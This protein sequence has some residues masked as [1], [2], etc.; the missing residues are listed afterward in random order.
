MLIRYAFRAACMVLL[1]A[2]GVATSYAQ[3]KAPTAEQMLSVNGAQGREF[4]IAI[5]PNEINPFPVTSL[6]IYIASAYDTEAFVLDAAGGNERRY[7]ITANQ[8]RTLSD[9]TGET[10]WTWEIRQYEQVIQKGIR[11]KADKPISVYVLNGKVT[12][13]DGYL[14]IPTA[15][16]G[17][18][19]IVTTYYDFR[20]FK[21]WACGFVI[22]SRQSGTIVD[23]RLKG[24]GAGTA[25]TSGGKRIG[26]QFQVSLEEGDVYAVV[27]DGTSRGEFDLT[28]TEIRSNVPVGLISF[29]QRTTMPNLLINGNGRDHLCEMTPPV[30]TW[31][32]KYVTVE[33][34]R[35]GTNPNAR[36]DV[37]RVIASEPETRWTLKYY[38]KQSKTV[39]G[40]G[41]GYLAN[42]GDFA[43]LTQSQGPTF[44]THG[45]SVWE[46]DKPIFVMQYA[47][48]A[49]FDGDQLHDPFM[50]NV[51]P[52]EQFIPNTIFQTPTDTK[53]TTHKL[54]L[55]V[56][57]D[58]ND[59]D[60]VEN[61][62]SLVI[63]DVPVWNHPRSVAPT[64]LFNH[65]GNNLH[66]V[67][68][69]F[70]TEAKAHV[71]KGN[72]KVKFGGYIYG[73]GAVDSYGWPA[74]SGFRPTSVLDTMPPVLSADTLCGDYAYTA[75]EFRNIP[76]PPLAEPRDSDQVE[77]GVAIIDFM[78]EDGGPVLKSYNYRI[79]I[80]ANYEQPLPRDPSYREVKFLLEVIDK[81]KD[82]RA[83]FYVQDWADNFTYDT[84]E[85]FAPKLS[86]TPDPL[87][88]GEVRL[89]TSKQLDLSITNIGDGP[90][91]LTDATIEA[92]DYFKVV[93]GD[94]PP[95]VTLDPGQSHVFTIEYTGTRET[96]D[97]RSDF[98]LDTLVVTADCGETRIGLE[99]VA[100]I[101]CI[102]VEDFRAGT[103]GVGDT[104]CKAGGLRVRNP[105]SDTLV[106]TAI[107][108]YNGTNFTVTNLTPALPIRI[109]PKGEVFVE[110]ICYSRN[111][112]GTDSIDVTF[113]S[114]AD[115]PFC[116]SDSVS[117]WTGDTE[118]PGP[119]IIGHNWLKRR[120]NTLHPEFGVVNVYNSGNQVLTLAN[121][122]FADGT[123]Y[124]PPGSNEANY[125]FKLGSM[126]DNGTAVPSKQLS[127]GQSVFVEAWFRPAAVQ[128]YSATIQPEWAEDGVPGRTALL[129]GEGIIPDIETTGAVITCANSPEGVKVTR[130]LVI[131]N[132][133]SEDLTIS[134]IRLAAGTDPAWQFGAPPP[135]PTF[136]VPFA[137]GS[138]TYRVPIEFTRPAG[139]NNAFV[140]NVEFEHD[141]VPGNGQDA[142]ITPVTAGQ[143]FSVGSCSGP[144]IEVT[145]IDFGRNLANCETPIMEF[146]ITNTGGGNTPLEI[147]EITPVGADAAA[148]TIIGMNDDGGSPLALPFT[149]G[150]TRQ[151]VIRV[152]FEPTEPNAAPWNDRTY[153]AQFHIRNYVQGDQNELTPDTYV[154]VRGVGFVIPVTMTL[155]NDVEGQIVNP[156]DDDQVTF[157]VDAT[158]TNWNR[159]DVTQFVATV[160][161]PTTSLAL[162]RGSVQRVGLPADWVIAAPVVAPIA[163]TNNSSITFAANGTTPIPGDGDLFTFTMTLLLGPDFSNDQ[164]L[165]LEFDRACLVPYTDG[166]STEITN[167]ALTKRV[168]DIGGTQ[169]A[170]NPVMPNPV[171]SGRARADFA[172]GI[173]APTVIEV[174]D[175]RG[176]VVQRLVD[177]VLTAGEYTIEFPTTNLGNGVYFLRLQSADFTQTQQVVIG[178]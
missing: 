155:S 150:Q 68:I 77:T 25:R 171:T 178:N 139:N 130:D 144:A 47:C 173:K 67:Q 163:G 58:V 165:E 174:V 13:S 151:A 53:F 124:F 98:D 129:E 85:Y 8:I 52:E 62:K 37:F 6:E 27:G 12:T 90:V 38:D 29:H 31:G 92:G 110:T 3:R 89:G 57:A 159:A 120:V 21:P 61:L 128:T 166:T 33:Y 140:L 133:G 60:Y 107:N 95:N 4:W 63:D 143:Q 157:T 55:I 54:N 64:L 23:I 108:G 126:L 24:T 94:V 2:A 177:Q 167:C 32:K 102:V 111:S 91:M 101:P 96:A 86:F 20:E 28:G 22:V 109:L 48:S 43:D 134:N 164:E 160:I 80:P 51:I 147:R 161:Y 136:V 113:S 169:F 15:A 123:K 138:N 117:T 135:P 34:N 146:T 30:E 81:S 103:L 7:K 145:D 115:G 78:P 162:N 83:E 149:L 106:I 14:A 69:D 17:K 46:A 45:Y 79:V 122:T 156:A 39:L 100:G 104:R 19:H 175:L 74:A 75:T 105:G 97:I 44:L 88:F 16:W 119:G 40:S 125:V 176:Q 132:N 131:T 66:W 168:V 82:A 42:A 10:N 112:V 141:A 87:R 36:G 41:G 50:I 154:N 93:N 26:D 1:L 71:I 137:A 116:T 152:R 99:G 158:S 35:Q 76:D 73:F 127:N 84:V 114:N 153:T 170:F 5:P 148:F 59:P 121:V 49:S 9:L 65:M 172:I 70:G 72:G 142:Q 18:Q 118:S 11:I 56:H